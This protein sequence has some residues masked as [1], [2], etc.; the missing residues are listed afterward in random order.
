MTPGSPIAPASKRATMPAIRRPRDRAQK[1]CAATESTTTASQ[2][3]SSYWLSAP[4]ASRLL[5]EPHPS[6][7]TVNPAAMASRTGHV[8]T[9]SAQPVLSS[10]QIGQP[11][12]EHLT[13][14]VAK[15]IKK[16]P[17]QGQQPAS[18]ARARGGWWLVAGWRADDYP[19][20]PLWPSG[21]VP[22]HMYLRSVYLS[23]AGTWITRF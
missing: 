20:N 23:I 21:Y 16:A 10:D 4:G 13:Q 15:G 14:A 3:P 9:N 22:L 2:Q 7:S 19:L 11:T 17:H 12:V 6:G 8:A 18:S 5:G 1:G